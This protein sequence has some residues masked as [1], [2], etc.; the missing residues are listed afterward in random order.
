MIWEGEGHEMQRPKKCKVTSNE[1][2]YIDKDGKK[3]DRAF[4]EAILDNP[5]A[6]KAIAE[7][8]I[9]R[10]IRRGV[11]PEEAK[12]IFSPEHHE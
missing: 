5:E 6:N 9:A 8:A 7:E 1:G 2:F 11:P 4:H 10:A 12:R 3:S